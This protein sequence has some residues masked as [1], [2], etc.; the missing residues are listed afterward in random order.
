MWIMKLLLIEDNRRLSNSLK[1]NLIDN[2]FMV[3]VAF[4]GVEGQEMAEKNPYDIIILDLLLPKRDGLQVCQG[5]RK[6]GI[7]APILILT[8]R[9]AV[10]D[11]VKGLESGADDYLVKP[12]AI[13]ELMSSLHRLLRKDSTD[14]SRVF[15]IADL[16]LDPTAHDVKRNGTHIELTAKEFALLE[17]FMSNPNRLITRSMAENYLWSY[18]YDGASNVVDVYI[19]RLRRKIDDPFKPK[20]IETVRGEGYRM[21]K[22]AE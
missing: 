15:S 21:R 1:L 12:F 9:D 2:G 3:D 6:Q 14:K 20:L 4:D 5:L 8:A 11:R 17:Y 10:E 13:D 19:R 16:S 18:D 7:K 22:P